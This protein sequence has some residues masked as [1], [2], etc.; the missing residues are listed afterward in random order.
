[1]NG[2]SGDSPSGSAANTAPSSLSF[3]VFQSVYLVAG[4]CLSSAERSDAD[5]YQDKHTP[6]RHSRKNLASLTA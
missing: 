3:S 5:L 2:N 4:V 1:M 6:N